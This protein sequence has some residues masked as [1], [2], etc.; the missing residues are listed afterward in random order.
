MLTAQITLVTYVT[1]AY[2]SLLVSNVIVINYMY[3]SVLLRDAR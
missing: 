1:F 2:Y 3:L